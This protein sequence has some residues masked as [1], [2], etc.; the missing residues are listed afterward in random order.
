[1]IFV[2]FQYD[3]LHLCHYYDINLLL[4]STCS[5]C[6]CHLIL[7]IIIVY[8]VCLLSIWLSLSLSLWWY[9][10]TLFFTSLACKCYLILTIIVYD[11]CLLLIWPSSSRSLL[12][13]KFTLFSACLVCK[14]DLFLIIIVYFQYD[15]LYICHYHD[16]NLL[17]F[18]L[19]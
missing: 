11:I 2:Y 16:I 9:K 6:K 15:S 4:F 19:V 13:Y 17:C 8:D 3:S 5:A 12:W 18:L 14:C 1:M 10:S 7:S